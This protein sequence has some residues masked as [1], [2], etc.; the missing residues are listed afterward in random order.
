M[1]PSLL[2]VRVTGVL[3]EDGNILI[4]Q[5]RV[6]SERGWSLPGGRVEQGETLEDAITREMLEETGLTVEVIKLLY[7]CDKPDSTP[8]LLHLTFLVRRI[9]G[10]I[11]NPSNEFDQN[12]IGAVTFVP[13]GELT[14]YGFSDQ[15]SKLV[16]NS[17]PDAGSYKG[18]KSNI[19]L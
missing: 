15:F 6:T 19:G 4:V 12:P 9:G 7:V 8:P 11:R 10:E 14:R 17:F 16:L 1:S 18:L 3:V 13:C 2:Q 5:Q